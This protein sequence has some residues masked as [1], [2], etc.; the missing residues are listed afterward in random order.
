MSAQKKFRGVLQ[1]DNTPLNWVIVKVP[2]DP[3]Q[4]WPERN[5]LRVKGTINGFP[6]RTSLFGSKKDG[7]VLLVNKQMQKGGGVTLGG[8]AQIVIEPDFE[9]RAASIPAE[10]QQILNQ[11]R[12]LKKWFSQLSYYARKD[13]DNTISS[14]KSPEGRRRQ[15]ESVAERLMLAMEGE[16]E[17]PPVLQLAFRRQPRALDG[18]NAMT[19]IQRRSHLLGIFYYKS[20]E[21]RQKRADKAVA[22]ALKITNRNEQ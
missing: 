12:A 14:G 16:R 7:H 5:R 4:A 1:P 10:L 3:A 11:D 6:F 2:F 13:I 19:P 17:M 15:A 22:E 21:S 8:I 9:E 18:W 20:P